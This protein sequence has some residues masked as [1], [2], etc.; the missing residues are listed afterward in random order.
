MTTSVSLRLKS[1]DD[2][3]SLEGGRGMEMLL[4]VFTCGL[5]CSWLMAASLYAMGNLCLSITVDAVE[6]V[7]WGE[8][9]LLGVESL[10][11]LDIGEHDSTEGE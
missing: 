10:E 8:V 11:S 6:V 9:S 3:L 5:S 2:S 1:T 4:N 7:L